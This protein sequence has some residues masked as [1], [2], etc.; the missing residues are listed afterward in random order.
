MGLFMRSTLK[1]LPVINIS[2]ID[3][4]SLA[5]ESL[6]PKRIRF[7]MANPDKCCTATFHSLAEID[8]YCSN[9]RQIAKWK[10]FSDI[11]GAFK[12]E[13]PDGLITSALNLGTHAVCWDDRKGPYLVLRSVSDNE[14]INLGKLDGRTYWPKELVARTGQSTWQ[15]YSFYAEGLLDIEEDPICEDFP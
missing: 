5:S 11:T 2:D 3:V 15:V 4:E 1:K 13:F 7:A 8:A 12:D 6:M 9:K 14:G 10:G